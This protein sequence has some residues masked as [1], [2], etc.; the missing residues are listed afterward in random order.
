MLDEKRSGRRIRKREERER[1][2]G[3]MPQP[4]AGVRTQALQNGH[5]TWKRSGSKH[6]V[7]N[8]VT[9]LIEQEVPK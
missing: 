4:E 3:T 1:D 2:P 9:A 7:H 8:E 5:P 6:E